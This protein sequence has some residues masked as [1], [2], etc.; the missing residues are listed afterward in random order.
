MLNQRPKY[1]VIEKF[2]IFRYYYDKIFMIF[3]GTFWIFSTLFD[4]YNLQRYWLDYTL[5]IY[6]CFFIFYMMVFSINPKLL[7]KKIY[8]SFPLIT[9]MRGRGTLLVIISS[10][11]LKDIYIF[12]QIGTIIIFI[13]GLFYFICEFLVPTTKEELEKIELFYKKDIKTIDIKIIDNKNNDSNKNMNL[14][15]NNSNEIKT[16]NNK[17]ILD[18]NKSISMLDRTEAILNEINKDNNVKL[19]KESSNNMIEEEK[20]DQNDENN[21][22]EEKKK[23]KD[24][25]NKNDNKDI[26]VEDEIVYKTDNPYEIPDDF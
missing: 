14:N 26:L 8:N 25:I 19:I 21:N 16:G 6:G 13:G 3:S 18:T 2:K 23:D 4:I 20:V 17:E 22:N 11:F 7:P 12:H 24:T 10:L 9:T 5:E 1:D 15:I